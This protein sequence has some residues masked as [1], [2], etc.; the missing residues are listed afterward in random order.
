MAWNTLTYACG[1]TEDKQ[2]YGKHADRDRIVNNALREDC[3]ACRAAA[4]RSAD[5][6]AG[7]PALTGSDK[8]V[9]WAAGIRKAILADF[10]AL[11]ARLDTLLANT[12]PEGREAAKA[13]A[14]GVRAA[15]AAIR[16]QSSASW[17]IE[18]RATTAKDL[19]AAVYSRA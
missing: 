16:S 7:L 6:E 4:A 18:R 1:H 3:A 19:I 15:M 10:P 8:Q 5:A 13:Q 12:A 2:L 11:D 9:A 14:D 17:W